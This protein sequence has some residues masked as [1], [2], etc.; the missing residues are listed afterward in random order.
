MNLIA[1]H[2]A[3]INFALVIANVVYVS[4]YPGKWW[5]WIAAAICL[6]SGVVVLKI[7]LRRR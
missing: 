7:A 6:Y 2:L 1:I 5:H 4:M 3:L